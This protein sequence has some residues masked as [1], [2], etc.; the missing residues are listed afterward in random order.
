[1]ENGTWLEFTSRESIHA[2]CLKEYFILSAEKEIIAEEEIIA[3]K[4]IIAVEEITLHTW[5]I[6]KN[7]THGFYILESQF[8]SSSF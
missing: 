3:E 4:E 8:W 5:M 2:E 1:M 6:H 7:G